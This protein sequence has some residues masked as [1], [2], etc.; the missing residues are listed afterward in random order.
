MVLATPAANRCGSWKGAGCVHEDVNAHS[1]ADV[2][3]THHLQRRLHHHQISARASHFIHIS[4]YLRACG[5]RTQFHSVK[6]S[7]PRRKGREGEGMSGGGNIALLDSTSVCVCMAPVL[8]ITYACSAVKC[9][10]APVH[11]RT[12]TGIGTAPANSQLVLL[13]HTTLPFSP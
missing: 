4:V 10:C 1:L 3:R 11:V 7:G 6:S 9:T 2:R 13:P 5:A 12:R 8:R